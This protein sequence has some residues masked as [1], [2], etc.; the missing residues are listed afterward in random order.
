MKQVLIWDLNFKLK[1]SGG[2]AG[3]LY[4]IKTYIDTQV[5]ESHITFLSEIYSKSQQIKNSKIAEK[6]KRINNWFL[7]PLTDIYRTLRFLRNKSNREI[8]QFVDL[9]SFDVIHF[10]S[11]IDL[12]LASDIISEYKGI[13]LLTSHS[14]EPIASELVNHIYNS[15]KSIFKSLSYAM[16]A[17]AERQAFKRADYIMFPT[18]YSTEPYMVDQK[19]KKLLE[20]K[21]D[22]IKFCPTA[23]LDVTLEEKDNSYFNKLCGTPLDNFNI[24]YLGRHNEVKG[25]SDLKE[26]AQTV[27]NKHKNV[28]FIIGGLEG[29]IESLKHEQWIE[30]GWTNKASEIIRNADVFILPNRQT[31]F[32]LIALEVLRAGTPIIMSDTGGN[33]YFSEIAKNGEGI[34]LYDRHNM[35]DCINAIEQLISAKKDG[36]IEEL[37]NRNRVLWE[38]H[39]T[40]HHYMRNYRDL[41]ESLG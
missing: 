15:R 20:S 39:F 21:K 5:K 12:Y 23:T 32:D 38:R 2:P 13:I 18:I 37:G 7:Q 16:F 31:Y 27:L 26:I 10:H 8:L 1:N 41:I 17:S 11:S 24:I 9:S 28:S 14:P 40:L 22:V 35:A 30:L 6:T 34:Y 19:L 29:P 36:L 4:N 3:Y 33:K 25:Y